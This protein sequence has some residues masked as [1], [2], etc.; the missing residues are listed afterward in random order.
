MAKI[1]YSKKLRRL[2]ARLHQINR[3][4]AEAYQAAPDEIVSTPFDGSGITLSHHYHAAQANTTQAGNPASQAPLQAAL[5]SSDSP[6]SPADCALPRSESMPQSEYEHRLPIRHEQV[7]R[8]AAKRQLEVLELRARALHQSAYLQIQEA[9][10]G[11]RRTKVVADTFLDSHYFNDWL[12][13]QT[14]LITELGKLL[15]G[16]K[17]DA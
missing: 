14:Q 8:F 5:P 4:I 7:K 17:H 13:K 3:R 2:L 11:V 16:I 12:K 6:A 1:Q 9:F 10:A 15:E